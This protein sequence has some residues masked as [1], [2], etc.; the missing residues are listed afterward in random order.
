MYVYNSYTGTEKSFLN[1]EQQQ[2]NSG[3]IMKTDID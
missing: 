3:V 2:K 1:S